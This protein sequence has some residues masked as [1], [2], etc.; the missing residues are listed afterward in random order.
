MDKLDEARKAFLNDFLNREIRRVSTSLGFRSYPTAK[1]VEIDSKD[2][3]EL[4]RITTRLMEL[5][6]LT[7]Q[8]GLDV[9][10][11]GQFPKSEDIG[12]TQEEFVKERKKGFYN[13][14]VGGVPMI[15]HP[16]PPMPKGMGAGLPVS[17]LKNDKPP[18]AGKP[19]GKPAAQNST[20]KS[21]GRPT[22]KTSTKTKTIKGEY[23]RANIQSIISKIEHFRTNVESNVKEKY[24]VESLND[25]QKQIVDKL[26]ESIVCSSEILEWN[27]KL[28]SCVNDITQI[29]ELQT[30]NDIL[31]ISGKHEL[32]T[33]ASAILYHSNK[34]DEI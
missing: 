11:T 7:P 18:I 30:L 14:L 5:G 23:S 9:F 12:I 8:Q 28:Q 15:T 32:E 13:P 2:Q 17:G 6:V 19:V 3:A 34:I 24:S 22:G 25:T 10:N 29:E 16:P 27:E 26:C 31:D 1:F 21:A 4:L 33:Y 20:P